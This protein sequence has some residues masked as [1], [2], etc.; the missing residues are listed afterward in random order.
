MKLDALHEKMGPVLAKSCNFGFHAD[1][2][3]FGLFPLGP[4]RGPRHDF[5]GLLRKVA[6]NTATP[7]FAQN[8]LIRR[9]KE[10]ICTFKRK[11]NS[12]DT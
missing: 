11:Y 12:Y 9:L 10:L 3:I 8:E 7:R 6:Q 4:S 1:L 5:S 2:S